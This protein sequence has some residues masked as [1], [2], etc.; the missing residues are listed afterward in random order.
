[1]D[2]AIPGDVEPAVDRLDG[3]FLYDLNDLEQLAMAGRASREAEARG[4]WRIIDEAVARFLRGRAERAG[5]PALTR[6]RRYFEAVRAE[7]LAEAGGDA[8]KATRLLVNRLL[9]EPTAALKGLAADEAE[10]REAAERLVERL[11]PSA[12]DDETED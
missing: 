12:G 2:A 4:A 3:A 9:H 10:D 11:F 6:L 5:V 7:V 1:M 8:E